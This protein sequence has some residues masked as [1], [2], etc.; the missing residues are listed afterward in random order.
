MSFFPTAS[1]GLGFDPHVFSVRFSSF[2][3]RSFLPFPF[4]P[5]LPLY[6]LRNPVLLS[7]LPLSLSFVFRSLC[8]WLALVLAF[9]TYLPSVRLSVCRC[10]SLPLFDFSLSLCCLCIFSR[11]CFGRLRAVLLAAATGLFR[12]AHLP[13]TSLAHVG[14]VLTRVD[15]HSVC[16]V[17]LFLSGSKPFTYSSIVPSLS[18]IV[19]NGANLGIH[20][21]FFLRLSPPFV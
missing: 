16:H 17:L 12:V 8:L 13:S 3:L 15:P 11:I 2:F 5:F 20:P 1:F 7:L 4:L 19:C 14:L 6:L 9:T 10:A 18:S 21:A